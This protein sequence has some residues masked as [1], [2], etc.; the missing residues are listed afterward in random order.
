MSL[1]ANWRNYSKPMKSFITSHMEFL[2]KAEPKHLKQVEKRFS[3]VCK[4]VH[5]QLGKKP[6]HLRQRLN[7]AALDAVM[8]CS[9]EM[10]GSLNSDMSSV[11]QQLQ[12]NDC[13]IETVTH[14]TSD[15]SAV[16]QRF[17]LTRRALS[18]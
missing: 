8:A 14:N 12:N 10:S 2:D 16:Q 17:R 7:L 5:T 18:S 6:F 1:A 3:K 4:K 11:Y 9:F 13:F 15:V